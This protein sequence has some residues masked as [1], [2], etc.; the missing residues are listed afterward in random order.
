MILTM[1]KEAALPVRLES[2]TKIRLQMT[3]AALGLSPSALIRILISSFV[4]EFE[5]GGGRILFPPQ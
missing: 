5:R 1:R 4:D 2:E 3:A